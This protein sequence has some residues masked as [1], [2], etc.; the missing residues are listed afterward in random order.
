M[1]FYIWLHKM[2]ASLSLYQIFNLSTVDLLLIDLLLDDLYPQFPDIHNF[3][4]AIFLPQFLNT[5]MDHCMNRKGIKE[6]D[7]FDWERICAD[8]SLTTTTLSTDIPVK[9]IKPLRYVNCRVI[10]VSLQSHNN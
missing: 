6:S 1:K 7:P 10:V 8:V 3:S 2:Y 9:D 4:C 5:L